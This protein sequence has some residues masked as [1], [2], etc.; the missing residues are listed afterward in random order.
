MDIARFLQT[1]KTVVH[2]PRHS[3][4]A[5][6][7]LCVVMAMGLMAGAQAGGRANQVVGMTPP[8]DM[9]ST[10]YQGLIAPGDHKL[11]VVSTLSSD[12]ARVMAEMPAIFAKRLATSMK[13]QGAATDP[14]EF[15][16][17]AHG[18]DG[19]QFAYS[20]F[21]STALGDQQSLCFVSAAEAVYA[22]LKETRQGTPFYELKPALSLGSIHS[23][24]DAL[25]AVT[26]H[27]LYHCASDADYAA[28]AVK[29]LGPDALPFGTSVNEMLADLAVVLN[30]A[31]KDGNFV[32][33]MATVNGMRAS[34]LGDIHHNTED[35]LG[36]VVARLD[37]AQFKEMQPHEIGRIVNLIGRELDPVNNLELKQLYATSTVEKFTLATRIFGD[38]PDTRA[39]IDATNT[40]LG[41]RG[42]T[43]AP[44]ARAFKV[45][46]AMITLNLKNAKIQQQLGESGVEAMIT[47]ANKFG[48]ELPVY[49]QMRAAVFDAR[50]TSNGAVRS[51]IASDRALNPNGYFNQLFESHVKHMQSYQQDQRGSMQLSQ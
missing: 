22:E 31:A 41:M 17:S 30:F 34:S 3:A 5:K 26:L 4:L 9:V 50:V 21:G 24:D 39:A 47:L 2:A 44:N 32:N 49:Q 29:L 13:E 40:A 20:L 11:M 16:R 27:E 28:E 46:D 18:A 10:F 25:F 36:A 33:G 12:L 8:T 6:A 23:A 7:G 45:L 42:L 1:G 19:A 43:P 35:M 51:P 15:M 14:V 38:D 37:P 48:V